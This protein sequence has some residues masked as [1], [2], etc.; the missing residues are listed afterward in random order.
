MTVGEVN[1]TALFIL[2]IGVTLWAAIVVCALVLVEP[3]RKA[4]HA[5]AMRGGRTLTNGLFLTLGVGV[6]ALLVAQAGGLG[7]IIG[8]LIA[9]GLVGVA[10][11]GSAGLSSVAAARIQQGSGAQISRFGAITR[12]AGLLV[13]AGFT[14][15][16]GWF[17]VLPITMFASV[18]AGLVGLFGKEAVAQTLPVNT[19]D[20]LINA[21][22]SSATAANGTAG[23]SFQNG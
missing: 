5:L 4:E 21:P 3:T 2:A 14:P 1:A 10:C 15:L 8:L 19:I 12:A 16:F 9:F 11:V 6:V 23:S 18:G 13:V 20:P 22:A 17:F 7:Q